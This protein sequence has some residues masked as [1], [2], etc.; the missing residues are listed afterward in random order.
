MDKKQYILYCI[1][2]FVVGTQMLA[3]GILANKLYKKPPTPTQTI[4][5]KY[6]DACEEYHRLRRLP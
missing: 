5:T 4:I 1:L 3:I 2:I 6:K